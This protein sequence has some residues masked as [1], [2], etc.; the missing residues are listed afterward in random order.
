MTLD[1]I[2]YSQYTAYTQCPRNWYLSKIRKAEGKQ[3]WYMAIGSAVHQMIEAWLADDGADRETFPSAEDFFYPIISAQMEVEPDTSKWLAGG[4]NGD[5]IVE[6][7]A[8]RLVK[9]CFDRALDFLEDFEIWEVEYDATGCLPGLEVPVK[10]YVDLIGEH[11]KHGP[12][13]PDWKTGSSKPKDNFQLETYAAL[14]DHNAFRHA[15]YTTERFTGLWVMLNP[16]ASKARPIDLSAVDPA[17]VGA[18]Y[19]AVYQKMKDKLYPY[20]AGYHC[21][22]FCYNQDNC[23]LQSGPT[24]RAK[25]YD[26][27]HEDGFP[28]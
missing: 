17:E 12:A 22:S 9:E 15:M 25:F 20:Q 28:F 6:D 18:K 24:D 7:K 21:K 2:S 10:A 3:T 8:L 19:Q 16:K 23:I 5:P 26:R 27:A 4:P 13:I 11:K 1:H 14:L